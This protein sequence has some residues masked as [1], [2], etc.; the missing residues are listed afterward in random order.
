MKI[1]R[2]NRQM[3]ISCLEKVDILNCGEEF[4]QIVW[5]YTILDFG[6]FFTNLQNLTSV[7]IFCIF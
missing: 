7:N 5:G 1:S 2:S 6:L 4:R 3:I